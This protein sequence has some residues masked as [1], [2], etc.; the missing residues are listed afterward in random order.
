[1]APCFLTEILIFTKKDLGN[2]LAARSSHGDFAAD[3]RQ[4]KFKNKDLNFK[5]GW[6]KI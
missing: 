2:F 3:S 5:V 4:F 6:K 1:M